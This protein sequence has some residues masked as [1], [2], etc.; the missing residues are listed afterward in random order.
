VSAFLAELGT[1]LADRWLQAL[2]LPGLLWAAVLA[3]AVDLGQSHAFDVAR[4]SNGLD[5]LASRPAV[6]APGTVILA[7]AAILLVG[8]GVGLAVGACGSLIQS[9]WALPGDLPPARWLLS[10]RRYRWDKANEAL[11]AAIRDAVLLSPRPAPAVPRT[12]S[13]EVLRA[14]A[15][16]RSRRR[17]LGRKGPGRPVR[18]T[19]IGDRF[20]RA[21][22]RI[23]AVNGLT[24][25]ATVWPRLWSVLPETM[26]TDVTAA[27]TAYTS[28]AR[29]TA[30]GLLY[31]VLAA[32]WLPAAAIGVVTLIAAVV[33]ARAA[34][35]VLADLIETAT[36]LH[37]PALAGQLSLPTDTTPA[38]IGRAITA[39][40]NGAA[41]ATL[42]PVAASP[43]I[44]GPSTHTGT[45]TSTDTDTATGTAA[46]TGADADPAA[47][48][49]PDGHG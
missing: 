30:W 36:D 23:A 33:Q 35:D 38:D 48:P 40:L 49:K 4:L 46:G 19:R 18:P 26:R 10:W 41:T 17:R 9:L 43:A 1:K 8:A 39:R 37:T 24:D 14:Q 20:A 47:Q 28:T 16:V 25:L 31:T 45:D 12:Q 2:L 13:A 42:P 3:T 6:H 27:R 44:P 7:A 34:A 11:K 29:L 15:R 5:R 22:V 21:G 32:V